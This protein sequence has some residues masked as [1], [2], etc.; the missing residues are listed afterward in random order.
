MKEEQHVAVSRL[1]ADDDLSAATGGETRL[2]TRRPRAAS[3][4][5]SL[6]PPSTTI[7]SWAVLCRPIAS[8]RGGSAR[9]SSKVGMII[10]ITVGSPAQAQRSIPRTVR[11]K[12]TRSVTVQTALNIRETPEGR[13]GGTQWQ[14]DPVDAHFSRALWVVRWRRACRCPHL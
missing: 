12:K 8:S 2:R 1:G 9:S 6:L 14:Q 7:T 3:S 11:A 13:P 4:V 5:R 10:E